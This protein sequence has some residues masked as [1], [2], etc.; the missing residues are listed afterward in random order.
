MLHMPIRDVIDKIKEETGL[1]EEEVQNQIKAK[2]QSL[3]GLV[4]EEGAAYI[5]ASELGVQ[6][7][8]DL[9]SG[10]LKIKNVLAG[11]QNVEVIGKVIKIREPISFVKDKKKSEVASIVIS[12]G[13]A[14]IRVVIWDQ[15]VAWIKEGKIREGMTVKIKGAYAKESQ[16]GG[17]E[18]HLS[19]RSLLVLEP[20]DVEIELPS[21]MPKKKISELK[22][23]EQAKILAT[24]VKI[25]RPRFYLACQQCNKK[26]EEGVTCS[27]HPEAK[28]KQGVAL[29]IIVDDGS[30]T[31]RAVAFGDVAE[32]LMGLNADE[33]QEILTK[34]GEILFSERLNNFLL[35][36][37][38]EISGRVVENKAFER[39]EFQISNVVLN[40][41][42][43]AIAISLLKGGTNG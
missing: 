43:R 30:E 34:D 7:F 41:D 32:K 29:N 12:D 14:A 31:M 38:I 5:V 4:S 28:T 27:A 40:P 35:G 24:V 17:V 25:F 26:L 20:Q 10:R 16:Y 19:K 18:L 8:K 2:L 37:I 6:L 23:S 42:P 22:I 11:M 1:S 21:T 13:S 33:A 9:G 15:R 3:E 36:R 39:E